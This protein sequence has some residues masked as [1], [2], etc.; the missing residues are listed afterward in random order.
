MGVGIKKGDQMGPGLGWI[1]REGA[2]NRALPQVLLLLAQISTFDA[3]FVARLFE[4]GRRPR[5]SFKGR[6]ACKQ[7]AKGIVFCGSWC[8]GRSDPVAHLTRGG[9]WQSAFP[10][11]VV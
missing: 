11:L 4:K 2:G 5:V 6:R 7:P 8:P 3:S 9:K 1:P 10:H